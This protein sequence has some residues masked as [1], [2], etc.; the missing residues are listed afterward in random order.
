MTNLSIWCNPVSLA[1]SSDSWTSGEACI[2][3]EMLISTSG[4]ASVSNGSDTRMIL[5]AVHANNVFERNDMT[6]R[7]IIK[8]PDTDVLVLAIHYYPQMDRVKEFW[9]EIGTVTRT[10]DLRRFIPVHDKCHSQS[11]LFL[12]VLPAI[13]PLTGCNSTSVF[14]R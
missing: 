14:F 12:K 1:L 8:M 5:H 13:H 2:P 9:I 4:C 7:V 11:P 6:G 10:T 3:V